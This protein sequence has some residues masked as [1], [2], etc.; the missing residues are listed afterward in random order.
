[1]CGGF[2]GIFLNME[3]SPLLTKIIIPPATMEMHQL[4]KGVRLFFVFI[5]L[6]E[7]K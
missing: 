2:L 7:V 5:E 6:S 3:V 4:R 1:M